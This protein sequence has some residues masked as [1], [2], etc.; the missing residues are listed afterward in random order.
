MCHIFSH[1]EQCMCLCVH[2]L[3][4]NTHTLTFEIDSS[5]FIHIVCITYL[6]I[7]SSVCVCACS[8]TTHTLLTFEIDSSSFIHIVCVTCLVTEGINN[9]II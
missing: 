7:E 1:R 9:K 6:V 2:M 5:N 4:H 8:H 3:T